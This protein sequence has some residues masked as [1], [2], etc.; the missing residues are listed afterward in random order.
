MKFLSLSLCFTF[1]IRNSF[2]QGSTDSISLYKDIIKYEQVETKHIGC[3]GIESTLFKKIDSLKNLIGP[4]SFI[5]Y[6]SDNSY[7]LKYYS[8][9]I[10][11]TK[12]DDQAFKELKAARND[13]TVI[14]YNF[15][16]QNR[17][18]VG[19]NTL[20]AYEYLLFV[21]FKYYYGTWC[22]IHG[23]GYNFEKK[24]RKGW[25]TRKHYFL[26]L[27]NN[28][29]IDKKFILDFAGFKILKLK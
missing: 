14:D 22:T 17:G 6:Y 9:L 5:N 26:A 11:M 3:I 13:T 12:D 25:R 7:I 28:S 20:I 15:A 1:L 16:G 18:V 19:F 4:L 8:F 21:K 10:M 23:V 24:D 29:S 27:V 2:C